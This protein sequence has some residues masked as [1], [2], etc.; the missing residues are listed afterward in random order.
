MYFPQR[1]LI[2]D[3]QWWSALGGAPAW[4]MAC[5]SELW[6]KAAKGGWRGEQMETGFS[7]SLKKL[8]SDGTCMR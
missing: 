7:M 2:G 4:L 3:G 1:S 6:K 5:S 8:K